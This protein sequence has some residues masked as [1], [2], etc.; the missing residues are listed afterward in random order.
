MHK[1]KVLRSVEIEY[2]QHFDKDIILIL[3]I[4]KHKERK[5]NVKR[6]AYS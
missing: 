4:I 2:I 6:L 5:I 1:N 3:I